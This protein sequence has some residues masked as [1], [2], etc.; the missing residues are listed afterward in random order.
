MAIQNL[1]TT[2]PNILG[3]LQNALN[4]RQ[5]QK[6]MGSSIAARNATN[7]ATAQTALPAAQNKVET[8][9]MYLNNPLLKQGGVAGQ[10]GSYRYLRDHQNQNTGSGAPDSSLAHQVLSS[11]SSAQDAQQ[12]N[13]DWKSGLTNANAV[14]FNTALGKN[15]IQAQLQ[16]QGFPAA[17]AASVAVNGPMSND[18][19][20]KGTNFNDWYAAQ[21]NGGAQQQPQSPQLQ[22]PTQGGNQQLQQPAQSP[23]PQQQQESIA[24]QAQQQAS[25]TQSAIM[26]QTTTV[27]TQK[28]LGAAN[29]VIPQL[30]NMLKLAPQ[31]L[32]YN[33]IQGKSAKL[34]AQLKQQ[35]DPRYLAYKEYK[36]A[37]A[38]AE[39]DAALAVGVHPTDKG[40]GEFAP[41]F[42]VD[43]WDTTP[44]EGQAALRNAIQIINQEGR[45]NTQNLSQNRQAVGGSSLENSV[46]QSAPVSMPKFNSKQEG[47][48]WFNKQ[49]PD[50]QEKIRAQMRGG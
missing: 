4:L 12:A 29:R 40:F 50:V 14:R 39:P 43:G 33:L 32:Q 48:A 45:I 8:D 42:D 23:I 30:Q 21:Q 16:K 9:Q 10:V 7:N 18:I 47:L 1:P 19:V 6:T 44:E 37:Q 27:D 41:L 34:A 2:A 49:S 38:V 35:N 24:D 17:V 15:Q 28:R 36:Q 25:E 11:L 31:A 3:M 20:S 46:Q 13:T 5:Q 22:Q 26:K